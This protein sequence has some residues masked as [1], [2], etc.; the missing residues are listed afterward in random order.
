MPSFDTLRDAENHGAYIASWSMM[1]KDDKRFIFTA[2]QGPGS[3]TLD[4]TTGRHAAYSS[5]A[6]PPTV[7]CH[8]AR[9]RPG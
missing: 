9:R 7:T 8:R 4:P 2:A 3:A 5:S 6:A 1:L